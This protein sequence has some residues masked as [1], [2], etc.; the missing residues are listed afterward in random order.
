MDK[1]QLQNRLDEIF[2]VIDRANKYIDETAPWALGK[3]ESK[4]ARLAAV[5]YNLLESIRICTTLLQPVMPESCGKIF[6]SWASAR[7]CTPGRG[8][9]VGR[10]ACGRA[11]Q[12]E[13]E[14]LFPRIDVEDALAKLDALQEAQKKRRP[15][16]CGG[17]PLC[18]R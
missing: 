9:P 14:N 3:D 6:A 17:G 18:G 13:G 11:D 10:A 5:L 8:R 15:P 7:S 16:R 2:K 12:Q 4:R 1:L